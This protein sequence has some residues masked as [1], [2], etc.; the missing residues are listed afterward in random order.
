MKNIIYVLLILFAYYEASFAQ[1]VTIEPK[2]SATNIIDIKS[3]NKALKLPIVVGTNSIGTPQAGQLIFNQSTSSPNYFNGTSWQN[4][5]GGPIPSN[6]YPNSEYFGDPSNTPYNGSGDEVDLYSW[7]VPTGVNRVWA[8]IWSGGGS[9]TKKQNSNLIQ[10]VGGESGSYLSCLINVTP[11]HTLLLLVGKGRFQNANPLPV[12]SYIYNVEPSQFETELIALNASNFQKSA[13]VQIINYTQSTKGE[14]EKIT[15]LVVNNDNSTYHFL[16]GC[17]G[18]DAPY[19]GKG[20][21]SGTFRIYTSANQQSTNEDNFYNYGSNLNGNFPGGGGGRGYYG[22]GK[23][24]N[25]LI[26]IHW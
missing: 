15:N 12:V 21:K 17:E 2:N 25:G 1:S 3:N 23:G 7:I 26:I 6:I 9:G 5:S 22:P 20:G 14:P 13:S 19:G 4:V 16:S 8:E 10:G 18:G 24:G 11:G